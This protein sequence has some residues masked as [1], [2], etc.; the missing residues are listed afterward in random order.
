MTDTAVSAKQVHESV[1]KFSKWLHLVLI[2]FGYP[3]TLAVFNVCSLGK[4]GAL[5]ALHAE[6]VCHGIHLA[7][8]S[9]TWFK[10]HH[11]PFYSTLPGYVTYRCHR[12]RVRGV[13]FAISFLMQ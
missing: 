4:T 8:I 10:T 2:E 3:P 1:N 7:G 6:I 9:D 12:K 11:R 5:A 13:G